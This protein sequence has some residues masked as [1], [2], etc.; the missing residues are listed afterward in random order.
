MPRWNRNGQATRSV[1]GG[2]DSFLLDRE[3]EN[4]SPNTIIWYR[5]YLAPF[6][7]YCETHG[8]TLANISSDDIRVYLV[9][10]QAHL[11]VKSQHHHASALR[12]FFYY[13][14]AQRMIPETDN[15]MRTIKMPRLPRQRPPCFTVEEFSRLLS[16][17]PSSRDRAILLFLAD[18]GV[19]ASEFCSLVVGD[20]NLKTG[21]VQVRQGKGKKDRSVFLGARAR[22][23]LKEVRAQDGDRPRQREEGGGARASKLIK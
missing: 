22:K 20:V 17:A 9:G 19:R 21:V 10:L 6:A 2:I 4:C 15:P 13:L 7:D 18:T 16:V 23:S 1:G 11:S 5:K 3:Q 8:H 12:A 14:V